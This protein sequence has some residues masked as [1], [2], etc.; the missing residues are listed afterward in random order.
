MQPLSS[1]A[2]IC[3]LA[4]SFALSV[5][6]CRLGSGGFNVGPTATDRPLRLRIYV[7][8]SYASRDVG[9]HAHLREIVRDA[10][11][12]F[13]SS[14][15]VHLVIEEIVDGWKVDVARSQDA[16]KALIDAEPQ[17]DVDIV[18]GMLGPSSAQEDDYAG[19]AELAGT[20]MVVRSADADRAGEHAL[21]VAAFLHE[22][23]HALGAPHDD[24]SGSIMNAFDASPSASFSE[25]SVEIIRNGLA[26]RG[27]VASTTL[28]AEKAVPPPRDPMEGLTV[29]ERATFERAL[30]AERRGDVMVAWQTAAPLFEA[31]P[32]VL[33][34]QDLRCRLA[35]ARDL[36]WPE[37]R[38]EC[39]MLMRLMTSRANSE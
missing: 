31:H 28:R 38:A 34:V 25:V 36:S 39:E 30:D 2:S 3:V 6:A 15:G 35:R 26:R 1:D 11:A 5:V 22:L 33:G 21:T 16:L 24:R 10:D 27:I 17:P 19:M 8:G 18:V 32:S 9:T 20:H 14:V 4:L 12:I 29:A 7:S 13:A 37:V 23:G